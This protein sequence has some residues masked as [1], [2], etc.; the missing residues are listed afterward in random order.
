MSLLE[1]MQAVNLQSKCKQHLAFTTIH[2]HHRLSHLPKP[3]R[4]K[5]QNRNLPNTQEPARPPPRK[6]HPIHAS[7]QPPLSHTHS[8]Q[9]CIHLLL[10]HHTNP[11]ASAAAGCCSRLLQAGFGQRRSNTACRTTSHCE[12]TPIR[13][14]AQ[15]FSVSLP[16]SLLRSSMLMPAVPPTPFAK[17]GCSMIAWNSCVPRSAL[18]SGMW[19]LGAS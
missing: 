19:P 13:L 5:T 6:Q 9:P 14:P 11:P 1:A 15:N 16:D 7:L 18:V 12:F 2:H 8:A 4:E 17:A 10:S 3:K